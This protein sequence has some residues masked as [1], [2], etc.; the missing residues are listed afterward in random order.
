MP[1]ESSFCWKCGA[2]FEMTAHIPSAPPEVL[3]HQDFYRVRRKILAVGNKY[4]IENR[5]GVLLGFSMKKLF[6]I[7]DDIFLTDENEAQLKDKIKA[8]LKDN[9]VMNPTDMKM[10]TGVS[11]KY[12]IP[13][14][15]YLDRIRLT[16]RVGDN[17]K[18]SPTS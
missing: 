11:R 3:W 16:L 9:S 1:D 17:R 7:K 12:A 5:Q 13:Y 14:M 10:I 2:K 18:L 6:R 4:Y 15:E 8:F